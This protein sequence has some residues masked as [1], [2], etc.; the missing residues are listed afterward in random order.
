MGK[1]AGILP[2]LP[3]STF[4][5][6]M[7]L[8]ARSVALSH[9]KEEIHSAEGNLTVGP[10]G[11]TKFGKHYGATHSVPPTAYTLQKLNQEVVVVKR[12]PFTPLLS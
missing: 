6:Y 7:L 8:E 9:M 2:R 5:K 3:G 1:M 10:D 12:L 4:A 11:K